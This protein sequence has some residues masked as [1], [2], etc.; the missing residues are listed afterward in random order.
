VTLAG[1]PQD[2]DELV[3][4]FLEAGVRDGARPLPR[5]GT[6]AWQR[7]EL[8]KEMTLTLAHERPNV[9]AL[10]NLVFRG[11]EPLWR[12]AH[13]ACRPAR[14]SQTVGRSYRY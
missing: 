3:R 10:Q 13:E 11:A 9:Y 6:L 4:W 5:S 14:R 7:R 12:S 8:V 1:N 2:G